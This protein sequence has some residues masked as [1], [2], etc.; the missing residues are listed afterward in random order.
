LSLSN[1]RPIALPASASGQVGPQNTDFSFTYRGFS[2]R[3]T[4]GSA[5]CVIRIRDG[6][7]IT[8]NVL[9]TIAL[10][11]GES[12]GDEYAEGRRGDKGL[13]VQLVSGTMPEGT[14]FYS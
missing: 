7:V 1:V 2:V 11:A 5:G 3:E 8:G 12:S 9:D 6:G 10:A 14:L 13:Y 4:T